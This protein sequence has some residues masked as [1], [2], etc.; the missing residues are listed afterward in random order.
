MP[1]C[2]AGESVARCTE[3]GN[4]DVGR[5]VFSGTGIDNQHGRSSI[6]GKEFLAGLVGLAH[7]AFKF[8]GPVPL[9]GTKSG[10][11]VAA[12]ADGLLVLIPEQ[13]QGDAFLLQF[14]MN[15]EAL[16]G[17]AKADSRAVPC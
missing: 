12:F 5:P 2:G 1:G 10:V 8:A 4:E 11:L 16:S 6:V 7:R 13:Q 15:Q 17:S 3:Y 14:L 9:V